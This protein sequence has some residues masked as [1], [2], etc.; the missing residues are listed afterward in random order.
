M[1]VEQRINEELKNAIKSGDRIRMDTL[2]SIRAAII[3]FNKSGSGK[4]LSNEEAYKIFNSLAKKRKDAIEMYEK[5]NRHDLAGKEKLELEIIREFLPKQLSE[6]EIR[7]IAI[8]KISELG[9][10]DIKDAGKVI[11]MIMKE[12]SGSADG[13]SVQRIVKE[14]LEGK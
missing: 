2:R 1:N 9:V 3:E 11:G 6:D 7:E 8:N 4:D 12:Y 10:V 5:G 14:L 13:V